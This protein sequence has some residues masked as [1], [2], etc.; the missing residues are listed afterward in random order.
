M[1][2][3]LKYVLAGF[4]NFWLGL[5]EYWLGGFP[6]NSLVALG[7]WGLCVQFNSDNSTRGNQL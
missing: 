6:F 7:C 5:A 3:N 4:V 1:M 2:L